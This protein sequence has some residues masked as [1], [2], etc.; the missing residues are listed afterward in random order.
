MP[1]AA[2]CSVPI[3]DG[4]GSGPG[5]HGVPE[6]DPGQDDFFLLLVIIVVGF[7]VDQDPGPRFVVAL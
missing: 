4:R 7:T 3:N 1:L 6:T 5:S 2:G